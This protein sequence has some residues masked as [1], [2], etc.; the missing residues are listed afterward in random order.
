[1]DQQ[2]SASGPGGT[3]SSLQIDTTFT[4]DDSVNFD[5]TYTSPTRIVLTLSVDGTGNYF[6]GLP[7]GAVTNDTGASFASFHALLVGALAGAT[8]NQASWVSGTFSNGT[9]F[10]PP[11]PDTTQVTYNG[12]PGIGVGDTTMLGVGF[13]IP[14]S[15][16][17]TFEVVLTPTVASVPDPPPGRCWQALAA[18]AR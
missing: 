6:I 2:V 17:Q 16:P 4:T 11:F 18:W 9:T 13:S 15:G 3:V 1:M 5:A 14:V 12:P 7:D 10:T 8:F